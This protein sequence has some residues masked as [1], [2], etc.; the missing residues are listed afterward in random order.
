MSYCVIEDATMLLNVPVFYLK[1]NLQK[2]YPDLMLQI[3]LMKVVI[4]VVLE[5]PSLV[6]IM[7]MHR[8]V[9]IYRYVFTQ[10]HMLQ[11][12]NSFYSFSLKNSHKNDQHT[13]GCFYFTSNP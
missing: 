13:K 7:N 8:C 6:M 3:T 2:E 1:L 10:L 11:A 5:R 12:W 9:G 4:T